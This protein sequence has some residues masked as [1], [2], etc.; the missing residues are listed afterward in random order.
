[1]S[2]ET[3][4]ETEKRVEK[5]TREDEEEEAQ[6]KKKKKNNTR[7]A[8][9]KKSEKKHSPVEKEKI[10]NRRRAK[11]SGIIRSTAHKKERKERMAINDARNIKIVKS[12]SHITT[13]PTKTLTNPQRLSGHFLY[14][15]PA[16]LGFT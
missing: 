16:R 11:P 3:R 2:G 8:T 7:H 9:N 13:S 10:Y 15:G 14:C 5:G 6:K 1:M 12:N 4:H